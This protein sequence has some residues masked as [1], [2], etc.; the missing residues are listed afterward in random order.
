MPSRCVAG[1]VAAREL[2]YIIAHWVDGSEAMTS[3]EAGAS[4]HC[5]C[6]S[7]PGRFVADRRV[8]GRQ[9]AVTASS[10]IR[11]S[12]RG[13]WLSGGHFGANFSRTFIG[14]RRR[15]RGAQVPVV[16]ALSDIWL[17]SL[18]EARNLPRLPGHMGAVRGN[19]CIQARSSSF[20]RP[21][22]M[23]A[24]PA[25]L[26]VK[27]HAP[28]C[29]PGFQHSLAEVPALQVSGNAGVVIRSCIRLSGKM[30]R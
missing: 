3:D 23:R 28:V 6:R 26:P 30:P 24:C 5:S 1:W 13:V 22:G 25:G 17:A 20:W 11:C 18:R 15:Y 7:F 8:E 19:P 21:G 9:T 14:K 27:A 4:A 2:R 29:M 12:Q 10:V 16:E